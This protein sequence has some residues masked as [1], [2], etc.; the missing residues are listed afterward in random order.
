MLKDA[1]GKGENEQ[2]CDASKALS[3]GSAEAFWRSCVHFLTEL[4]VADFEALDADADG[5]AGFFLIASNG[6]SEAGVVPPCCC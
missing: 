6:G 5:A 4:D 2:A 3:P 1:F